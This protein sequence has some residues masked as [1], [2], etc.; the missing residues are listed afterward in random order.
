MLDRFNRFRKNFRRVAKVAQYPLAIL[1]VAG[2]LVGGWLAVRTLPM[3]E[4]V[5][6]SMDR[7][8]DRP[9]PAY[10]VYAGGELMGTIEDYSSIARAWS[11]AITRMNTGAVSYQIDSI[12]TVVQTSARPSELTA[13]RKL[14][15]RF[16]D[17]LSGTVGEYAET[18]ISLSIGGRTVFLDDEA[19]V[20]RLFTL[21]GQRTLGDE[22]E[23]VCKSLLNGGPVFLIGP[24]KTAYVYDGVLPTEED[25]SRLP[26]LVDLYVDGEVNYQ[27]LYVKERDT[28]TPEEALEQL[29][30]VKLFRV[31]R[32][33][34]LGDEQLEPEY[35]ENKSEDTNYRKVVSPGT[36]A[37][38]LFDLLVYYD[39]ETEVMRNAQSRQQ[40]TEGV[41][42]VVEK[43]TVVPASFIWPLDYPFSV[44]CYYGWRLAFEL[45]HYGTQYQHGFHGGI[46]LVVRGI[47]TGTYIRAAADGVVSKAAWDDSY[48]YLVVITH[49]NGYKTWYGHNSRLLVSY[50]DHVYQG[51][52][53]ALMGSTGDSTG[54]HCH[55]EITY[56]SD[57]NTVD[58]M[59]FPSLRNTAP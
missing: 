3:F 47:G 16:V 41:A 25:V 30:D 46:D 31:Y 37:K 24:E 40:L 1:L 4:K 6:Y 15:N 39:G 53:I 9:V 18:Q 2:V 27:M 29:S 36:P 34:F 23:V 44:S 33:Y 38:V 8:Y 56:K 19:S 10:E 49:G 59:D 20:C 58:P 28:V 57:N 45:E 11:D 22:S 43:G 32:Q 7:R 55:F 52:V 35:I 26:E 12:Y 42:P 54:A 17:F 14:V 13:Q 48:G 5:Q 21:M 51:Q 50:G